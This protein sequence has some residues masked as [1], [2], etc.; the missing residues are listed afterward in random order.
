MRWAVADGDSESLG[1]NMSRLVVEFARQL[2]HEGEITLPPLGEVQHRRVSGVT[3]PLNIA[4]AEFRRVENEDLQQFMIFY[5]RARDAAKALAVMPRH[6]LVPPI[7][8]EA[9]AALDL[10]TAPAISTVSTS[11]AEAANVQDLV[12]SYGQWAHRLNTVSQLQH[13][14]TRTTDIDRPS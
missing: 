8:N 7:P 2:V 10:P 12:S 1:V 4:H 14:S 11:N 9:M 6:V 5:A 13:A 3:S